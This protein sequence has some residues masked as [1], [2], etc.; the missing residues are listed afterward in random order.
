MAS[1][2]RI[3]CATPASR[4]VLGMLSNWADAVSCTMTTPPASWMSRMP[5]EPSVPPPDSTIATARAPQSWASDRKKTSMGSGAS[6]TRSRSLSSRRPSEMI[7][8]FLG[9]I[10]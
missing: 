1:G 5:R 9:G 7:I 3:H 4:A 10:R 8:S 6:C 2:A